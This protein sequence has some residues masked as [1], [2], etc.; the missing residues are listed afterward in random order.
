MKRYFILALFGL[1][2]LAL[3]S[4]EKIIPSLSYNINFFSKIKAS[5]RSHSWMISP[6]VSVGPIDSNTTEKDLFKIFGS[7]KVETEVLSSEGGA[8][9]IARSYVYKG[10][11]DEFLLIWEDETLKKP[12]HIIFS[13][14]NSKWVTF[15]GIKVGTPIEQLSIINDSHFSFDGFYE[16]SSK[17]SKIQSHRGL[18]RDWGENGIL[19]RDKKHLLISISYDREI[20]PSSLSGK[21]RSDQENVLALKP[22]IGKI[23]V[24]L[25]N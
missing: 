7:S 6:G 4:D 2:F 5:S 17:N 18:V 14:R 3:A 11:S 9:L 1:A 24:F 8:E 12:S 15:N 21:L 10:T 20:T 23:I 19:N 22:Y 16:N 25:D 13:K